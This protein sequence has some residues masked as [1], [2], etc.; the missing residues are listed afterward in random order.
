MI[1]GFILLLSQVALA[2]DVVTSYTKPAPPY[3]SYSIQVNNAHEVAKE[4]LR[5]TVA[6]NCVDH[7]TGATKTV[8]WYHDQPICYFLQT[9]NEYDAGSATLTIHF[10]VMKSQGKEFSCGSNELHS[11]KVQDIYIDELCSK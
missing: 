10:S 11:N 7:H 9:S 2:D 5:L 6:I 1:F 4:P 3:G 8:Y